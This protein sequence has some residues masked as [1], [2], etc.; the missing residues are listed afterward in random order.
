MRCIRCGFILSAHVP[1]RPASKRSEA[2]SCQRIKLYDLMEDAQRI[3]ADPRYSARCRQLHSRFIQRSHI[4]HDRIQLVGPSHYLSYTTE[5]VVQAWIHV[6]T[7]RPAVTF[8]LPPLNMAS[9]RSEKMSGTCWFLEQ[10][11]LSTSWARYHQGTD[12]RRL[13]G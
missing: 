2:A 4:I 11:T 1:S 13:P 8:C 3:Y 12:S 7:S 5:P 9:P 10:F 6:T